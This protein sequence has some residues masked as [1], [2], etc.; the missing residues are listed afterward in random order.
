MK[1]YLII[2]FLP[3]LCGGAAKHSTINAKTG[4]K[5]SRYILN[6][7]GSVSLDANRTE[8]SDADIVVVH[9]IMTL[10][11]GLFERDYLITLERQSLLQLLVL[12]EQR[13]VRVD[14]PTD[15]ND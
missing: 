11:P 2:L 4:E 1:R 8:T 3:A 6:T 7:R 15:S 12:V 5:E 9:K 13:L 14:P 10:A